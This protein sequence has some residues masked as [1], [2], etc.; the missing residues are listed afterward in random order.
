MVLEGGLDVEQ[1]D[2]D[3]SD[4]DDALIDGC[5]GPSRPAS[6]RGAPDDEPVDSIP[7]PAALRQKAVTVSMARTTLLV[8]GSRSGQASSPVRRYLSQLYAMIASSERFCVSPA[9]VRGW[10]GTMRSSAMTDRVVTAP[11]ASRGFARD[12][13]FLSFEPPPSRPVQKSCC[14]WTGQRDW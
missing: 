3:R 10:F 11:I 6:L 4:G 13:G 1:V 8:I 14:G 7:P 2:Y 9:K 12:G 5:R